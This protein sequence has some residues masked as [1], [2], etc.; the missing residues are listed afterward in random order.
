MRLQI[1]VSIDS[2]LVWVAPRRG[3]LPT[4]NS[5]NAERHCL[6]VDLN[7]FKLKNVQLWKL[8]LENDALMKAM[9]KCIVDV[10]KM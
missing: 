6:L 9:S 4:E 3:L 1:D 10:E 8:I 2:S 5:V 7:R